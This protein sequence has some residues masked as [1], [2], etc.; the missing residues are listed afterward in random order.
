MV[1]PVRSGS[2]KSGARSPAERPTLPPS[3]SSSPM[4]RRSCHHGRRASSETARLSRWHDLQ[5][6]GVVPAPLLVEDGDVAGTAGLPGVA[7]L[8]VLVVV[9][10]R[11]PHAALL[12]LVQQVVVQRP[13]AAGGRRTYELDL[14]MV[15]V[16]EADRPG[17][18]A[19]PLLEEAD[20]GLDAGEAVAA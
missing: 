10:G 18:L 14:G 3:R 19:E 4:G 8:D 13:R 5:R 16:V 11:D 6:R 7:D 17:R 2:A 1:L 9:V 20:D 12:A 15:A